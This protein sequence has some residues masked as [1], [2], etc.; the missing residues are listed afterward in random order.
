MAEEQILGSQNFKNDYSSNVTI[1][2]EIQKKVKAPD[3]K[4]FDKGVTLQQIKDFGDQKK[5]SE[6]PTNNVLKLNIDTPEG[7]YVHYEVIKDDKPETIKS[8]IKERTSLEEDA[9]KKV[10]DNAIPEPVKFTDTPDTKQAEIGAEIK[11][12]DGRFLFV[13]P[14][15]FIQE[16]QKEREKR[17]DADKERNVSISEQILGER[18]SDLQDE[19]IKEQERKDKLDRERNVSIAAQIFGERE[20]EEGKEYKDSPIFAGGSPDTATKDDPNRRYYWLYI[21]TKN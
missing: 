11:T 13:P 16:L 10:P 7:K 1:K 15:D 20:I 3:P 6:L 14:K 9:I 18:E 2:G 8:W 4:I 5:A 21:Y 19:F 17:R 12:E